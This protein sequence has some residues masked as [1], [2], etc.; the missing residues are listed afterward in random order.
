MT[1]RDL[2]LRSLVEIREADRRGAGGAITTAPRLSRDDS[3]Q[4]VI[5]AQVR[6]GLFRGCCHGIGQITSTLED[7]VLAR[8]VRSRVLAQRDF[9]DRSAEVSN[10]TQGIGADLAAV[11]EVV[12]VA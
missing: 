7:V 8:A 1:V 11:R 9:R 12:G 2:Y 10:F 6:Q 3:I 5:R 4:G